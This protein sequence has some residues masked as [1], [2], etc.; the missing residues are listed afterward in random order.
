MASAVGSVASTALGALGL[1]N[2]A[3]GAKSANN[4]NNAAAA[5][6]NQDAS[7]KQALY[8]Y[9]LTYDPAASDAMAMKGAT[10][11]ATYAAASAEQQANASLLG[12]GGSP[13]GD[14]AASSLRANYANPILQSLAQQTEALQATEPQR[15]IQALQSVFAAP[16]GQIANTYFQAAANKAPSGQ[17]WQSALN[18]LGQGLAGLTV[19][20]AG[21]S[22][23]ASGLGSLGS[24][25][26]QSGITGI[27]GLG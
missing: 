25:L 15:K 4:Y 18:Y 1:Y 2:N 24:T 9:G 23:D 7:A 16:S 20:N 6:A 27:P 22:G 14:T 5:V 17:S 19:P 26:E 8:N 13:T 10:D 3:Q 21:L 11:Q 12:S